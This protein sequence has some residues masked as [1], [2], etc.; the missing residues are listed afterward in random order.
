MP[1]KGELT[2]VR[3]ALDADAVSFLIP[4]AVLGLTFIDMSV[5]QL[6]VSAVIP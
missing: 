6:V 4:S 2:S 5:L 3:Q 1:Y